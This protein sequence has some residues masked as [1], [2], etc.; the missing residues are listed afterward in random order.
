MIKKKQ[1][2]VCFVVICNFKLTFLFLALNL[3]SNFLIHAKRKFML[4]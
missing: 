4:L 1:Q 2:H 3:I